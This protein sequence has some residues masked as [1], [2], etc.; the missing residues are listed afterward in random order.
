MNAHPTSHPTDRTL[1][2]YGLG[3][4]DAASAGSVNRHLEV[5]PI[6]GNG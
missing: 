5:C 1:Q 4:L 2:A 3:Q 6:A